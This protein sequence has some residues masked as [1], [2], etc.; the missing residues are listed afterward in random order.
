M[1]QIARGEVPLA[2]RFPNQ[3]AP[4][5][6]AAL[7]SP[8]F[9]E[10]LNGVNN[11]IANFY[12]NIIDPA[13]EQNNY[14]EAVTIDVRMQRQFGYTNPKDDYKITDPQYIYALDLVNRITDQYN[15]ENGTNL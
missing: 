11:K 13:L 5:I 9:D 10:S 2:G 12:R 4:I 8:V 6:E 3:T 14:P 15:A 1:H 7:E